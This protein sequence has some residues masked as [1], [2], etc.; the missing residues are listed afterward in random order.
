MAISNIQETLLM[1]TKQ[2]ATIN[3]ELATI[4]LNI[5]SATRQN[6]D[7][8]AQYNSELQTYYYEYY[9]DD[10]TTYSDLVE[11]LNQE[12]E[13]DLANLESWE[14]ELE[15]EQS[16][17]ETQLNEITSYESSWQKLLQTNIKNDFTYGGQSSS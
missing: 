4:A 9:E 10:P 7:I 12:H 15:L 17:Y 14:S 2:K 8:Q 5:T 11:I 13:L 3:D 16:N 6:A 1:Y